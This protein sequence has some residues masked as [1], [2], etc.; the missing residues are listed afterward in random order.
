[1]D[2]HGYPLDRFDSGG[3]E[4][5]LARPHATAPGSPWVWRAEFFGAFDQADAAMLAHGWHVAYHRVSDQYGSPQAIG[6]MH[7]FHGEAVGRLG[8]SPTPVIFGFSRGGLYAC[9][10]ALAHPDEVSGL[11]LDAPVLDLHS[12]PEKQG[13]ALWAE[14]LRAYGLDARQAEAFADSPLDNA[15][16]LAELGVPVLL[17]VGLADASVPYDENGRPFAARYLAAGGR[18]AVI[19]KPG[20]GHHPHSL[21]NP[22]PIVDWLLALTGVAAP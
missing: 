8:L 7:D 18:L 1:M 5:L 19:E 12:W 15:E 16:R 17:V 22:A 13:A 3:R 9:N 21:E 10:Y 4:S 14:C 2:Y 11:Y 20:C 6:W